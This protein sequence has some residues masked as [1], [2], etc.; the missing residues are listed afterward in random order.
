[1]AVEHKL[2]ELRYGTAHIALSKID[3]SSYEDAR[4]TS[5]HVLLYAW[6]HH[7]HT[8]YHLRVDLS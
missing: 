3:W 4:Y 1:M 5:L 8:T 2:E 6:V 7:A